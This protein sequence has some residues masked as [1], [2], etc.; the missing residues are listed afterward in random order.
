MKKYFSIVMVVLTLL[1]TSLSY[2]HHKTTDAMMKTINSLLNDVPFKQSNKR[3]W[4]VEEDNTTGVVHLSKGFHDK[5]NGKPCRIVELE[6]ILNDQKFR[7]KGLL[8]LNKKGNW[9]MME[10]RRHPDNPKMKPHEGS[11]HKHIPHNKRYEAN[12]F[13]P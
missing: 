5:K 10:F 12:S 4:S 9:H 1:F 2:G 6:N 11:T 13:S 3:S 7:A 8:C